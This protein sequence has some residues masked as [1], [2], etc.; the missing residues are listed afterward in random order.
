M[1]FQFACQND[2]IWGSGILHPVH[3][4]RYLNSTLLHT[5]D[6]RAVRGPRTRNILIS[7]FNLT[8]PEIYGDPA[9]LL[10][11]YLT[12]YK[13]FVKP[14][15]STLLILHFIDVVK[16]LNVSSLNSIVT[17]HVFLPWN[18]LLSLIV[19]SQLVISTSLHGIIVSEAFWNTC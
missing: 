17:V 15:I 8:V 7:K 2:V 16:R 10:P 18:E 4:F 13:K 3:D 19:Q 1:Y 5:L 9:L 11:Y 6:I 14:T 12:S